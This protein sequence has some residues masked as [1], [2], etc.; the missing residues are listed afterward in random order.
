MASQPASA[1]AATGL[2]DVAVIAGAHRPPSSSL[3]LRFFSFSRIRRTA[4]YQCIK[5]MKIV[6]YNSTWP[7]GHTS[8]SPTRYYESYES[9][10]WV[11][12]RTHMNYYS[13]TNQPRGTAQRRSNPSPALLFAFRM[14]KASST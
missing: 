14:G 7:V 4:A 12:I 1:S 9:V 5:R 13:L 2:N 3:R 11:D 8:D 10:T 6:W